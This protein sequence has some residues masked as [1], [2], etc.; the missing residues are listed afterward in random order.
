MFASIHFSS[1]LVFLSGFIITDERRKAIASFL[2]QGG[3]AL[4]EL[5]LSLK[6]K[7]ESSHYNI[8]QNKIIWEM[9]DVFIL[10]RD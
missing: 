7:E 1:T 8:K 5:N 6:E 2:S 3:I 9:K 4:E 10:L